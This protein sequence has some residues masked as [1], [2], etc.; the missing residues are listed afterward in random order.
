[1]KSFDAIVI[2]S[3][4]GG[5]GAAAALA[6]QGKR[7]LVLERHWQTGGLTQTFERQGFRFNVGVHYLG[8]FG[9]H[10]L[11]RRLF[12]RLAGGRIEMAPIAGV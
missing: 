11:N 7:V 12:E 9:E 6:R 2:G 8:G 1:M 10:G 5:L 4:I 3:G